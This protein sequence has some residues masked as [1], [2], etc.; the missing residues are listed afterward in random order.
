MADGVVE[1]DHDTEVSI[2][3]NAIFFDLDILISHTIETFTAIEELPVREIADTLVTDKG[4]SEEAAMD[5]V[6]RFTSRYYGTEVFPV[7]LANE[8]YGLSENGVVQYDGDEP[9]SN[10]EYYTGLSINDPQKRA[11]HEDYMRG[12]KRTDNI[13]KV[14]RAIR[15]Y[16]KK[17]PLKDANGEK[18]T[19]LGEVTSAATI[20]SDKVADI[21]DLLKARDQG[22][23]VIYDTTGRHSPKVA[24]WVDT[25]K[26]KRRK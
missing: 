20:P 15:S 13:E 26:R 17:H 3:V 16:R 2:A 22:E 12:V 14:A 25:T 5:L 19:Q 4:V 23:T 8:D 7:R 6:N 9:E 11:E 1:L 21:I 10:R 18:V 24:D